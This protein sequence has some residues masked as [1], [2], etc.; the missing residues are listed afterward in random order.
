MEIVK[1]MN[2]SFK[3][4]GQ[5]TS[6]AAEGWQINDFDWYIFKETSNASVFEKH[7]L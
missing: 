1:A 2:G 4:S 5:Q 3:T 7:L 6:Q